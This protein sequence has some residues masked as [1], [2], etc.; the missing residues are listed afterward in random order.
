MI[1][2]YTEL[3]LSW[4]LFEKAPE[5][6][7]EAERERVR[8][9]AGRQARIERDVL[10]TREAAS[11]MVTDKA[12]AKALADIRARYQS[13][14]DFRAD[15]ERLGLDESS[16]QGA[17]RRELRVDAVL[18]RIAAQA[19][20]VTAVD[21]ELYYRTHTDAFDRPEARRLR[22]ILVT[23]DSDADRE[24]A[25][26]LLEGIRAEAPDSATFGELALRHS[27]CPTAMQAGELGV[28]RRGQLFEALEPVAFALAE[29]ALSAVTASP[30][31]LHLIRCDEI[32]PHGPIPFEEVSARIIERLVERR[33]A[34]AQKDW[35]RKISTPA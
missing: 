5:S 22:H 7:D 35:L 20:K 33:R 27:H 29:G 23:F 12:M 19:P 25:H 17:L 11:V 18:E 3:K 1:N 16:L 9:V 21:A 4:G 10:S 31:G 30:M 32:L 13:E 14:A 26:A 15:L 2:A 8:E 24:Q 6:L 34:L 28:V